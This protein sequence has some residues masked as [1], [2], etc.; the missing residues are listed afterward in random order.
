MPM[1]PIHDGFS[2]TNAWIG[3]QFQIRKAGRQTVKECL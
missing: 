1:K 3:A 2:K